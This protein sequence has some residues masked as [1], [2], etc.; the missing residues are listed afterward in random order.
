MKPTEVIAKIAGYAAEG[1]L[2]KSPNKK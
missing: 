1:L 2:E